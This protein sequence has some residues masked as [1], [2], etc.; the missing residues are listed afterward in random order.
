M[1]PLL[2]ALAV[3]L[4]GAGVLERAEA[5]NYPWCAHY[6]GPGGTNCGFSTREQCMASASGMGGT[7]MQ[8]TQYQAPAAAPARSA[9]P[10][11]HVHAHRDDP[12]PKPKAEEK[13]S[14]PQPQ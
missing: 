14:A 7:C 1:R 5:Q 8:N 11:T 4:G 13:A 2:F 6:A 9:A 12:R 3:L 10:M